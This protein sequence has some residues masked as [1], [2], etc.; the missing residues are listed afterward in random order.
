MATDTNNLDNTE[1]LNILFKKSLEVPITSE[2]K[3]WYEETTI[4]YNNYLNGEDLFLDPIPNNP[5][6]DV[7]GIV[8]TP[9][10]LNMEDSDFIN[11]TYDLNNKSACSIVDDSTGTVRRYRKVI[12]EESPQLGSDSGSSWLKYDLSNNNILTDSFQFNFKQY[13]NNGVT[14]QPY[15]YSLFS[16]LSI[17]TASPNIPFGKKGGNWIFETKSGTLIFNDFQNFSNG[18]QQTSYL[19]INTSNNKP[20]ITYYKYVG[21]RGIDNL[22]ISLGVSPPIQQPILQYV[23]DV[24]QT[25]YEI[26]TQQPHKFDSSGIPIAQNSAFIDLNWNYDKIIAKVDNSN[27]KLSFSSENKFGQLPFINTIKLEISGIYLDNTDTSVNSGWIDLSTINIPSDSFY[28]Q[29]FYKN[30][31]IDKFTENIDLNT[32]NSNRIISKLHPFSIRIYG[33]NFALDIPTVENRSIYF[34]N[35]NFLLAQA[36]SQPEFIN[37]IIQRLGN[38]NK[39]ILTYN[40]V[41]GENGFPTS[42]AILE[43]ITIEYI[44]EDSL[45]SELYPLNDVSFVLNA[46]IN[47][48]DTSNITFDTTLEN[49]NSGTKYEFNAKVKNN[50]NQNE[51][52]LVSTI[53]NSTYT[54]IPDPDPQFGTIV[55]FTLNGNKKYITNK[56]FINQNYIY[57]NLSD[58]HELNYENNNQTIELTNPSV[59][60]TYD[61]GYGKYIDNLQDLANIKVSV[62]N[63]EKQKLTFDG[64]F[65][66]ISVSNDYLNSNSFDYITGNNIEDIYSS[67]SINRG[68][69][70]KGNFLLNTIDSKNINSV[71]G[72][73]SINPHTLLYEY[74]RHQSMSGSNSS[75]N[76]NIYVDNL[77]VEPSIGSNVDN[78]EIKTVVYNTGIPSVKEFDINMQRTYNN[79]NSEFLFIPGNK[80]IS[81]FESISNTSTSSVNIELNNANIHSSGSYT[82]NSSEMHILTSDEFKNIYYKSNANRLTT[83]NNNIELNERL[84]NLYTSSGK[85]FT[86]S[87]ILNHFCDYNSYNKSNNMIVSSKLDLTNINLYEINDITYLGSDLTSLSIAQYSDHSIKM[88]DH[89]LLYIDNKFQY[90]S[91]TIYPTISDFTYTGVDVTNNNYDA[92]MK[93]YDLSGNLTVDNDGYKWIAFKIDK[94]GTNDY[95][96]NGINY[97][98]EENDDGF[99]Y[100]NIRSILSNIFNVNDLD[101]LF[102]INGF[103]DDVVGFCK[104]TNINGYKRIGNIKK[105][106]DP[107]GGI[108]I[109]NGDYNSTTT[110][111][112]INIIGVKDYGI[113]VEQDSSNYGIYIDPTAV[114]DDL[115]LFIGIKL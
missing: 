109:V 15:L 11:Y 61:F 42:L 101:K 45:R 84:Y 37:Y 7:S 31:R 113:K 100:L 48:L 85:L 74:N 82:F 21:K 25:F 17:G 34:N 108:W 104:V 66:V 30:F 54:A 27:A 75:L 18:I 86:N 38:N 67:S 13:V 92:Y 1:M 81:N 68:F 19:Q 70:L 39:L 46:T 71:L 115:T 106:I 91:S 103:N 35:I 62:N 16:E 107:T 33:I 83:T 40:V 32:H 10:E 105:D 79:I 114:Q 90:N 55:N 89:S 69:R 3:K 87:L 102:D 64:C 96:F 52:S 8:R 41:E 26:S 59:D 9:N 111:A 51:F 14:Y 50:L 94:Y 77:E 97:S 49:L 22:S 29:D 93:N 99:K 78:I 57:I 60:K 6:F 36:P 56:N 73:A 80:I 58:T 95:T 20:V 112:D 44:E 98:L 110:Y 47:N 53:S 28:N 4:K 43:E 65:N 12:L 5:D 72:D 23:N 24:S 2:K 88:K 63:V 76:Q